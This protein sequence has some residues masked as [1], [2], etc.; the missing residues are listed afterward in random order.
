MIKINWIKCENENWYDFL[1][2]NVAHKHFNSL[3]GVYI[4]WSNKVAVRL[5]SGVIK[6]RIIDHRDNSQITKYPNLKITWAK[7]SINQIVG[8]E[9]YL[10]DILNPAVGECFPN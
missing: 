2:V 5:G 7:V 4:I 1:K 6:E 9:K 8:V 10:S 3:N